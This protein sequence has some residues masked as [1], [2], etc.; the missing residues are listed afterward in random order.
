MQIQKRAKLNISL[1]FCI[2]FFVFSTTIHA[3]DY[4][5]RFESSSLTEV[6][7]KAKAQNKM[8]FVDCYTKWCGPCRQMEKETFT[9][10]A[11]AEYFNENFINVRID[12]E[13]AEGPA[14][15]E[16]HSI[17]F[18]PTLLFLESN[19]QIKHRFMGYQDSAM[20][21]DEVKKARSAEENF[22]F[23]YEKI[24]KFVSENEIASNINVDEAA[25]YV[26]Y[27]NNLSIADS[28][29]TKMY[30]SHIKPESF[31]D[32]IHWIALKNQIRDIYH[33][34]FTYFLE[35][36]SAFEKKFGKQAVEYYV[37]DIIVFGFG[38]LGAQT[39]NMAELEQHIRILKKLKP[40][41]FTDSAVFLLKLR[42]FSTKKD[43]ENYIKLFERD[44]DKYQTSALGLV[45]EICW[46]ILSNTSNMKLYQKLENWM[47][48]T[49][50]D[51]YTEDI[52][53]LIAGDN[54]TRLKK[55]EEKNLT[56]DE[57]SN[58]NLL[59]Q[60]NMYPAI[61]AYAHLLYK[62]DRKKEAKF[63]AE[64]AIKIAKI[65]EQDATETEQLIQKL[66]K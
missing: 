66:K 36:K 11:I 20:L 44:E 58:L 13:Q 42:F 29:L 3:Q 33:P 61:D 65:F 45:N 35:N 12:M 4:V 51:Q 63:Y 47:K 27:L 28:A 17:R 7:Q 22:A 1:C 8:V 50:L 31:L 64:K 30:F 37:E 16:K 19:G 39:K 57:I 23:K 15:S 43:W 56:K 52:D 55:Y 40:E 21:M 32:S 49:L 26:N 18:V 38:S 10:K 60:Y 46:N 14:F 9:Q 62:L 24:K 34:G 53:W 59:Y 54:K 48:K 2:L 25:G 6:L 41:N 5:I